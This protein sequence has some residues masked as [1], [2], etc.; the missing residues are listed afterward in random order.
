MQKKQSI[1]SFS[2]AE[3]EALQSQVQSLKNKLASYKQLEETLRQEHSFRKA[4]IERA[5]EGVCVCHAIPV[6]P[7]VKFTVWNTRMTE[8]TGYTIGEINRRGWY[9]SMY[10]DPVLQKN[11]KERMEQM[12]VGND[13]HGEHWE[14]IRSDGQERTFSISTAL[15]TTGDGLTHVLA[16]MLDVTEE[17]TYRRHIEKELNVLK[18]ILPICS[19]CKNIRDDKGYWNRIESYIHKHSEAEF[20]HGICPECMKKHFPGHE[21]DEEPVSGQRLSLLTGAIY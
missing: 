12:R 13:L 15:L 18:G 11:A 14:L 5:A 10:P 2:Q 6:Y 3:I 20:S 1:T 17:E 8:I 4:I 21:D 9:Q 16:L 7:Y 19:Y